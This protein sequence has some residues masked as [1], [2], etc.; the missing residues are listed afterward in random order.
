M[1]ATTARFNQESWGRSV[2]EKTMT[3]GCIWEQH[4]A[5]QLLN[6]CCPILYQPTSFCSSPWGCT[7]SRDQRTTANNSFYRTV[8]ISFSV[9]G[10]CKANY[11]ALKMHWSKLGETLLQVFCW[12]SWLQTDKHSGDVHVPQLDECVAFL[13]WIV[14]LKSKR[15]YFPENVLMWCRSH[16]PMDIFFS[17]IQSKAVVCDSRAALET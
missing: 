12:A 3:W 17:E 15:F 13:V 6:S 2:E 11:Y 7:L 5:K 4:R 8:L 14:A 9:Q 10:Y 16:H 1:R